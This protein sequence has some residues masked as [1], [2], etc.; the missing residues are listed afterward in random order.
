[1]VKNQTFQDVERINT[2]SK[3]FMPSSTECVSE[4]RNN[5]LWILINMPIAARAGYIVIHA[6]TINCV[7]YNCFFLFKTE[8]LAIRQKNDHNHDNR[9]ELMLTEW[10]WECSQFFYLMLTL[11]CSSTYENI[12]RRQPLWLHVCVVGD[13]LSVQ[14]LV[15]FRLPKQFRDCLLF[16][17][18][19]ANQNIQH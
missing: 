15:K 14:S 11:Q 12:V 1:M 7:T 16:C 18:G 10:Q 8:Y 3:Y 19:G 5:V 2:H 4:F 6:L 17:H 13:M 9:T